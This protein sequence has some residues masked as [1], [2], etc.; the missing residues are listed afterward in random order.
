MLLRRRGRNASGVSR[1]L[2]ERLQDAR[3]PSPEQRRCPYAV[4]LAVVAG[5]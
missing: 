4:T 2:L 3:V 5:I 1:R